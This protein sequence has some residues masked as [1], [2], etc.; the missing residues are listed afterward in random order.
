MLDTLDSLAKQYYLELPEVRDL[1]ALQSFRDRWLGRERGLLSLEMRKLGSIDKALR[2]E[3]GK[4]L[5]Q[6]KADFENKL[7]SLGAELRTA[8]ERQQ[9]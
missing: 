3:F 9:S 6:L 1:T 8:A 2:P 7:E 5:N 4:R